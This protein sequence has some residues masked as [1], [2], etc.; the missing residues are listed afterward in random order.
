[1]LTFRMLA[2][3]ELRPEAIQALAAHELVS[4]LSEVLSEID[5]RTALGEARKRAILAAHGAGGDIPLAK[6]GVIDAQTMLDIVRDRARTMRECKSVM[7]SILRA[8]P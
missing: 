6:V 4:A 1:M 2:V 7:Q 5:A 3:E 8:V